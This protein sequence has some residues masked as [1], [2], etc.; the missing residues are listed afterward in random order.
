MELQQHQEH[1]DTVDGGCRGDGSSYETK[2]FFAIHRCDGTVRLKPEEE[3]GCKILMN[4]FF[5]L[6][7]R[8]LPISLG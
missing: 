5:A 1:Q 7:I 4:P 8:G 6:L 3:S 2:C